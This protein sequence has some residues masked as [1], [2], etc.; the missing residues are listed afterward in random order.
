MRRRRSSS[1]CDV[2]GAD[3]A[4][5]SDQLR[6]RADGLGVEVDTLRERMLAVTPDQLVEHLRP[7]VDRGV[8]DFLL[9]A[10]PPMDLRTLELFAGEVASTLLQ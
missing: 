1:R 3:D 7:Y 5:I 8:G 10:R 2:L 9:M 6:A 4:E